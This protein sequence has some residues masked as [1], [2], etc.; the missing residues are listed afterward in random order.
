MG[1]HIAAKFLRK[2]STDNF[3]EST[4]FRHEPAIKLKKKIY[5]LCNFQNRICFDKLAGSQ[6][7]QQKH[8]RS[9]EDT[10]SDDEPL[11]LE[12]RHPLV[13][14]AEQVCRAINQWW[15]IHESSKS[16]AHTHKHT[17][18]HNCPKLF[19]LYYGRVEYTRNLCKFANFFAPKF[20]KS[21]RWL[22][23]YHIWNINNDLFAYKQYRKT[24]GVES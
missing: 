1:S 10:R 18:T 21:T 7:V 20:A 6:M 16:S 5:K 4:K 17:H 9:T 13:C 19:L 11:L 3:I 2:T 15:H 12:Q 14:R 22:H 23:L 24:S 8:N